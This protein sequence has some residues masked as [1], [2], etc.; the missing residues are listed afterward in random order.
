VW[1]HKYESL[2]E[3]KGVLQRQAVLRERFQHKQLLSL[4]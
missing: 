4:A 1:L 2:M 3:Q